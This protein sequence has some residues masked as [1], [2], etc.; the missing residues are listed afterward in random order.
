[1]PLLL[2]ASVLHHV[3][4]GRVVV[5]CVKCQRLRSPEAKKLALVF[6]GLF[7]M[8]SLMVDRV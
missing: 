1:M 3:P 7:E 8:A 5:I 4:E 2:S 6:R